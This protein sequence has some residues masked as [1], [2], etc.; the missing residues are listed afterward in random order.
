ME[1]KLGF[2]NHTIQAER[3]L[4][5][6]N[7]YEVAINLRKRLREDEKSE[8]GHFGGVN[9]VMNIPLEKPFEIEDI[10]CKGWYYSVT[11]SRSLRRACSSCRY[12]IN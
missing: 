5:R 6:K 12:S 11:H 10:E 3:T 9:I 2:D 8:T 7:L 1:C 4:P